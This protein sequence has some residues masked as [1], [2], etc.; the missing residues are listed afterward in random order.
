MV[1]STTSP[2][3][4][5]DSLRQEFP[6]L[7]EDVEPF[8]GLAREAFGNEPDAV[9]LWIGDERSLSAVHK[10]HYEVRLVLSLK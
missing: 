4:Q 5:N 2:A 9:N 6:G 10:D 1:L 3:E 7:M 8:L